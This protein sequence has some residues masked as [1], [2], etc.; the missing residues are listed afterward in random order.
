MAAEHDSNGDGVVDSDGIRYQPGESEDA[1]VQRVTV[2]NRA[3][4]R[5]AN[6]HF[7]NASTSYDYIQSDNT[8]P[9]YYGGTI[10]LSIFTLS[11]SGSGVAELDSQIS[12]GK[13]PIWNQYGHEKLGWASSIYHPAGP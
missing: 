6:Y 12:G 7:V 8:H 3:T 2:T 4:L 5:D 13:S 1:Y 11:G 10:G 9:T